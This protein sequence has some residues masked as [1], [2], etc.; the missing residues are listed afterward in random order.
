MNVEHIRHL[1]EYHFTR[2][3]KLLDYCEEKLTDGQL[4]Q[5]L[6]IAMESIRNLFVHIID[7]DERWF[8][9]LR[10]VDVPGVGDVT[11]F[12]NPNEIREHW[13]KIE[14]DMREYLKKIHDDDIEK[15]FEQ[16]M[17]VWHV[18]FHVV[19]HGTHHRAQIVSAL[20]Q[21]KID[22]IPQDYIFYVLGKI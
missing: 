1:Y 18:L 9:G 22:P 13:K 2:N 7:T 5:K 16:T 4:T 10:G 20:R 11:R 12:S 19:N 8:C 17:Q 14:K 3:H 21:L 15:P 6:T